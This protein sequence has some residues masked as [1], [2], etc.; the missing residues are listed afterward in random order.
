MNAFN[1]LKV[2]VKLI[3][4]FLIVALIIVVVSLISYT[5][6]KNINDGMTT[7]Y[8][9]RTL[10]IEQVGA[11]D[12]AFYFI[13]GDVYKYLLVP[14]ER[15]KTKQSIEANT[16][17]VNENFGKYRATFL[18]QEEK[19]ALALFDKDWADYQQAIE[20]V[21]ADVDAGNDTTAM[22]SMLDGGEASNARQAVGAGIDKIIEVNDRIAGETNTQGDVT[23]AAAVRM[24]VIVSIVGILLAIGLGLLISRGIT[25]PLAKTM[26]VSQQIAETDLPAFA[27]GMEALAQGDLTANVAVQAQV[28]DIHQKDE[29]GKLADAFNAMIARLQ[30]VGVT[31]GET[32]KNLRSMVGQVSE[33][34]LNL[35]AASGQLATAANQAGQATSQIAVTVQQVAEGTAQQS[36]S[37]TK[38][39]ASVEQMGRAIDGVA[40]GAQEQAAAVSKA[41]EVTTQITSAIQQV[42]A[43]AQVGASAATQA[44]ET[45]R[46]GAKT[47]E[48]T[49]LGMQSIK[50]KVGLS[51][52]KVQEMGARSEQIG[53]IVET[54]DDIASQTNLL[55]L[56]AAIEAARAGEHGKGFA[57]VADEVRKLA[58]KSA[59]AT[60]E[61]SDLIKTIQKTVKEAVAAMEEGAME[62]E[63]GVVRAN[64]SDE[65]LG[66]ILKA[67][68]AVNQQVEGIASAAQQISAS[69][70]ELISAMDTVSAV[71]E[72]NT[73][74][75]EQMSANSGEV[76]QAIEN[77]ASVSEENSASIEEVSAS[78]EEMSAQV[79]EVTASAQSL[80]EMAQAL[81]QIVAQFKVDGDE[82]GLH[83]SQS[84]HAQPYAQLSSVGPGG[85]GGNGNKTQ[86][87]SFEEHGQQT[88][89]V[90]TH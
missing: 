57:V 58:E 47:V 13:R 4:G 89:K 9:D 59:I 55:A 82:A 43:N 60:R 62:V 26:K 56:N 73:A 31:F 51:A 46:I 8:F 80:A 83:T 6:M 87:R 77:I 44:A 88:A 28:L 19:D 27:A 65:A 21:M 63:N 35:S 74:S 54:I 20:K 34:A 45:A 64:Q 48:D 30:G 79:E 86:G 40:K 76:T 32:V 68:E 14:G 7:L 66:S 69:S 38:T 61:I 72:E 70:N 15:A 23:F 50:T 3:G 81:Q 41:S 78:A 18:V 42:A 1:N 12:A 5:N 37:V 71:V 24:L 90:L 10:P 17:I 67:V 53:A 25:L 33:N 16:R 29:I 2:S 84:L 22:E 85:N 11:A 49:I 39:A 52:E 75:T 36:D